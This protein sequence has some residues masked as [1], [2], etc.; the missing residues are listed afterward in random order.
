M[1]DWFNL[2]GKTA[3]VTGASRGIG[4]AIALTLAEAGATVAGTATSEKGA[5]EIT[6]YFQEN[7]FNGKGFVLNVTDKL[8]V[9]NCVETISNELGAPLILINNAAITK[10]D[11]FLR[12]DDEE[13][14]SVIETNLTSIFR[15]TKA[16]IKPMLKAR[17]GRVIN[18]SS[19]VGTMGNP[20][21][22]NYA[23]AKAGIAG[24]SK[25]LG[26]ELGSRNIT[27]NI[28]SPGF[29]ETDMTKALPE[30]QQNAY[31]DAIPAGRFGVAEDIAAAAL[32][33]ASNAASYINGQNI[34]VN[35][36]LL[37]V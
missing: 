27:V 5:A 25:S 7:K 17:W 3:L 12:M 32:F 23:A 33:L 19:V 28:I 21:Q 8:S 30:A 9:K 2:S 24:F 35:G 22:V 6:Q 4:K 36:G 20:G 13:W 16:C 18:I 10:D 15:V 29:I 26:K 11:L 14:E 1:K 34:H 37:M 31:L